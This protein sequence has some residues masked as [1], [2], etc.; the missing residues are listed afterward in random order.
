MIFTLSDT[1]M[2]SVQV[3][4]IQSLYG[5]TFFFINRMK[6]IETGCNPQSKWNPNFAKSGKFF[7]GDPYSSALFGW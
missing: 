7:F 1:Q 3:L 2:N 4:T 6:E 5:N